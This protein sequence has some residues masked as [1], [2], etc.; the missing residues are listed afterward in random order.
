MQRVLRLDEK[1]AD[2][3][4]PAVQQIDGFEIWQEDCLIVCSGFEDRALTLLKKAVAGTKRFKVIIIEYL[5]FLPENRVDEMVAICRASGLDFSRFVFDRQ[6]PTGG[7]EQ[8]VEMMLRCSGRLIIDISAMS[9]LLVVQVLVA[10][11]RRTVNLK[12]S[13]I[14]Y[15]EARAYPPSRQEFESAVQKIDLDPLYSVFFLS[16]GV[17]NVTVVPELSAA[18]LGANQSRLVFFPSFNLDQLTTVRAEL[19]P[20]RLTFVHGVPPLEENRWRLDAIIRLN[21]LDALANEEHLR[22]ST[23]D[24]RETLASLIDLYQHHGMRE[25][26]LVSPTGSKMQ[27]VAVGLAKSFMNDLQIVYPTP[28][29][30]HSPKSYTTGSGRTFLLPLEAF[31]GITG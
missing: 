31:S 18:S 26:L 15:T 24:Y 29:E 1:L 3:P 7:G 13:F 6:N 20:S 12:R 9:R 22:T 16:S 25:R 21:N 27:T 11:S 19:Q 5:P 10:L 17:F 14:A 28:R 23:L 2:L 8:L 4:K 30:F